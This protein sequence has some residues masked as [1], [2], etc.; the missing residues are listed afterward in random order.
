M[1]FDEY[2]ISDV[3]KLFDTFYND[4]R[5]YREKCKS[6]ESFWQ[7]QHWK[8][9]R[10]NETGE[11]QPVTPV[12]FS[13]LENMLADI[14]D[15][16]PSPIIL[17]EDREDSDVATRLGKYIEYVLKRRGYKRIYR[18]KCREM[19]KKGMSVQEIYWD[20]EL[21]GGL[22]DVNIKNVEI[23]SFL[24]DDSVS[25][26]QL[27]KACFKYYF[28]PKKWFE[29]RYPQAVPHFKAESYVR[30]G[31]R[32]PHEAEYMLIEYWYKTYDKTENRECVH[33]ARLAGHTLLEASEKEFPGGLYAHGK[34]PFIV[35]RLYPIGGK[36]TGLS[37]I[38]IFKNLQ[39]YADKL[40][41]I[42]V[43]NALMSG[44]VKMLVNRG[45]E[46]D[47]QALCDWNTEVVRA[48]RIDDG[49]VRWFQPAPLNPAVMSHYHAKLA[50]IK[51]ESGQNMFNRGESSGGI[52]AASAIMA[53]QEAGSKRSR[54]IIDDLYDGF[55]ELV[56]MMIDVICENYTESRSFYI[57]GR[58][59]Y[60]SGDML[61]K[62]KYG[63][64]TRIVDFDICVH[65]QKQVPYKTLYQ[66]ELALELLK[67][68]ILMADE[69]LEMMEFEGKERAIE[70]VKKRIQKLE[71]L[72]EQKES[73]SVAKVE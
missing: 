53:M 56:R 6:N 26:L 44:K 41:Q 47:E 31:K 22:G 61:L 24:W 13:T 20:T 25:D 12:I 69:A 58:E 51:E 5:E 2:W 38:D 57:D 43:K 68:G 60:L 54:L 19:L 30:E 52:T 72:S 15:N 4:T 32:N 1:K 14:M 21:Y 33:M 42:I 35:E 28:Y 66:N 36:I 40:D 10:K 64:G 16:Y 70:Q 8:G 37:V 29:E 67:S 11:P 50:A 71:E 65:V 27:G 73:E 18:D 59:D 45:A 17:G 34:Y 23:D 7:A 3:Y 39:I 9:I 55:E 46:V 49:S 63:G 62:E 48:D